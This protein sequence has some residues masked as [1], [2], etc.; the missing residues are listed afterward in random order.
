MADS[1]S[2]ISGTDFSSAISVAVARKAM[3]AARFEG[4]AAVSLIKA[5]SRADGRADTRADSA[6][7]G[8]A[9]GRID[10]IG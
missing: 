2:G 9:R 1:L 8:G 3:E 5:A 4:A 6:L 10:V 7:Q